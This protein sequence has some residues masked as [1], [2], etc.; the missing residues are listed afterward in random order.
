MVIGVGDGDDSYL[1]N[2]CRRLFCFFLCRFIVSG[3]SQSYNREGLCCD[4]GSVCEAG[5]PLSR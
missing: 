4:D 2:E 1:A 3:I 5:W